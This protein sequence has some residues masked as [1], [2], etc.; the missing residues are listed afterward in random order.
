MPTIWE[1]KYLQTHTKRQMEAL[2]DKYEDEQWQCPRCD[3]VNPVWSRMRIVEG[4]STYGTKYEVNYYCYN[5]DCNFKRS[6]GKQYNLNGMRP[7]N[8]D[9]KKPQEYSYLEYKDTTSD[10]WWQI[11]LYTYSKNV[12]IRW[13]KSTTSKG[14]AAFREH[15][16]STVKE[17]ESFFEKRV[18]EKV[19]KGYHDPSMKAVRKKAAKKKK[20]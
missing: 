10:K 8:K 12:I 4:Y 13:G 1:D 3:E 19:R 14:N 16:F 11:E 17:A 15:F 9:R 7:R 6:S 2:M 18:A 20:R 5:P